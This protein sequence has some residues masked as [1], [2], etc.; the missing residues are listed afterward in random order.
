MRSVASEPPVRTGRLGRPTEHDAEPRTLAKGGPITDD[1]LVFRSSDRAQQGARIEHGPSVNRVD[2]PGPRLQT[3]QGITTEHQRVLGSSSE[4]RKARVEGKW[5]QLAEVER[6]LR[7]ETGS[8]QEPIRISAPGRVNLIGEYLDMNECFVFPAAIDRAFVGAFQKRDDDQVV[9]RSLN[10]DERVRFSL[11]DL[12]RNEEEGWGRYVKAVAQA[13]VTRGVKLSGIQGVIDS[14]VPIGSGLSS[15]AALELLIARAMS[16][17][18][19]LDLPNE[20][21]VRIAHQAEHDFVGVKCGIMDQY[22]SGMGKKGCGLLLD[23]RSVE[24]KPIRLDLRG[25]KL[26]ISDTKKKRSLV[27]S[28]FNERCDEFEQAR[29]QLSE[30][31]GRPFEKLRDVSPELFDSLKD[32]LPENLRK[33][34]EHVIS[35]N[36]RVLNAVETLQRDRSKGIE[37]FGELLDASHRSLRTSLEVTCFELDT[38]VDLCR[39]HPGAVGAR[40]TGAGFGGCSLT[41]VREDQVEDFVRTVSAQYR[42]ATGLDPE[43]HVCSLDDGLADLDPPP[44]VKA[45]GLGTE[46]SK[47]GDLLSDPRLDWS[48]LSANG[49]DAARFREEAGMI[50][51]GE[52]TPDSSKIQSELRPVAGVPSLATGARAEE[53]R[54]LGEQALRDGKVAVVVLNG[55]MATR[56]GGVVKGTVDVFDGKSFLELKAEDVAKASKKYGAEIPLVLMNS[57]ATGEKTAQHVAEKQGF[58]LTGDQILAFEQSISVRMNPDGSLFAGDDGKPSY[59]APGHGDFFGSIRDSG[60]LKELRDRGVEV[61]LFSNVDNL[62]ATID[63]LIIGHHIDAGKDLTAELVEKRRTANGTWDQGASVVETDGMVRLVEGFRLPELSPQDYPDFSTNNF[64]FSAEALDQDVSLER[65][66]VQKNVD[67]RPAIQ[68][69]SVTCEATGVRG[70][71]GEALL[72]FQ[73]LRVPRDGQNGRFFPIKDPADLEAQRDALRARLGG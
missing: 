65:W 45:W 26:V 66:A 4:N 25:Y 60:V 62:G 73:P 34:A 40:M 64:I 69:E 50:Q 49:F 52:L 15:S 21:L 58:G 31:A 14:K 48:F 19:G 9:I 18:A 46:R 11:K 10:Q 24:H 36:Q 29:Q 56:F 37:K 55:G 16:R 51:R 63:P 27:D 41:L 2:A 1:M 67:D 43:L 38:M 72:S 32:R 22:A 17:A 42:D 6:V 20:E 28:A 59:H 68:L 47:A 30:L 61:I 7:D 8:D 44:E 33:R 23:C 70:E 35:E 71:D 3:P 39:A 54:R 5:A 13:L 57:F 53:L 12:D